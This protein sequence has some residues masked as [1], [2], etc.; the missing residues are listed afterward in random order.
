MI[1][2]YWTKEEIDAADAE[3]KRLADY[4]KEKLK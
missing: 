4:F 2:T 1:P 3:A